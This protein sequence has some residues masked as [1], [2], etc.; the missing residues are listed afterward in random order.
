MRDKTMFLTTVSV[1][2]LLA[3]NA[4]ARD[5]TFD[6]VMAI[7]KVLQQDGCDY[8]YLGMGERELYVTDNGFDAVAK[9]EDGKAYEYKFDSAYEMKEKSLR[10]G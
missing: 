6:E 5:P 7:H 8:N 4:E 9:C 2:L 10:G 3:G 1:L